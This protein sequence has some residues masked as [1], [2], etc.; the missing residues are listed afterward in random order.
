MVEDLSLVEVLP[1]FAVCTVNLSPDGRAAQGDEEAVA[2]DPGST[3][4][5]GDCVL[6]GGETNNLT[7]S[8]SD[9]KHD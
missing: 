7:T 1:E 8:K 3:S 4:V 6:A 9:G 2:G 5:V